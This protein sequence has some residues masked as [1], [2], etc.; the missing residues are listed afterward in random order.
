MSAKEWC[1]ECMMFHGRH[2]T[3]IISEDTT[4]IQ[5]QAKRI[6]ELEAEIERI[7]RKY[8]GQEESEITRLRAENAELKEKYAR[9]NERWQYRGYSM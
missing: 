6:E 2:E 9:L 4:L 1:D 8:C 3:R 5:S 7:K